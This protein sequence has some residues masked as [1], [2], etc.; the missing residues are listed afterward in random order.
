MSKNTK[1]MMTIKTI[2]H[3]LRKSAKEYN[4]KTDVGAAARSVTS[5]QNR[6]LS[7]F[8]FRRPVAFP[9]KIFTVSSLDQVQGC[10]DPAAIQQAGHPAPGLGP[11]PRA[12][13]A[14]GR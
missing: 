4:K 7:D 10:W 13:A 12:G 1:I 8:L 6:F 14:R 11:R 2:H 3:F 9:L 5:L